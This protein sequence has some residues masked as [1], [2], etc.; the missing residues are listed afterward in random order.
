MI[1]CLVR[2]HNVQLGVGWWPL[3]W[4][5]EG[6][7]LVTEFTVNLEHQGS[8]ATEIDGVV[9]LSPGRCEGKC[10]IVLVGVVTLTPA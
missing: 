9:N 5:Q 1:L 2:I 3:V 8:T 10:R 7:N 4:R 6:T